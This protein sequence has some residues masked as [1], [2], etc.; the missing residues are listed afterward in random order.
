M[1]N[2]NL[3]E[4]KRNLGDESHRKMYYSHSRASATAGRCVQRKNYVWILCRRL[5]ANEGEMKR[6]WG[7][8][9]YKTEDD[10]TTGRLPYPL[11][12]CNKNYVKRWLQNNM[13]LV[14]QIFRMKNRMIKRKNKSGVTSN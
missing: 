2:R 3:A 10:L 14:L 12:V 6:Q 4:R 13:K 8:N 1:L 7:I 5:L 9:H 11:D